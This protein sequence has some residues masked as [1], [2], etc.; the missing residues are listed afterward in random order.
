MWS[1]YEAIQADRV[2]HDAVCDTSVEA[3]GD[4]TDDY[5]QVTEEQLYE[6]SLSR[7]VA[8]RVNWSNADSA[9][10]TELW[11]VEY[12][13]PQLVAERVQGNAQQVLACWQ[14]GGMFDIN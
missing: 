7:D 10:H 3:Y 5:G 6:T 11:R 2:A 12:L 1:V 4:I 14:E 8:A 13:H 9:N